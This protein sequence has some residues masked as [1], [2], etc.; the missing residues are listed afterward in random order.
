MIF[1]AN[2]STNF[3]LPNSN[4]SLIVGLMPKYKESECNAANLLL[5]ILQKTL[6]KVVILPKYT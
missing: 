5:K 2:L 6:K 3:R 4:C 1:T